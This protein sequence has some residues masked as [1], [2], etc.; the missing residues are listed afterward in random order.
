MAFCIAASG[1][2]LIVLIWMGPET[3]GRVFHA[4]E[5]PAPR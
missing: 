3:R 4:V 2:I 5:E 1:L